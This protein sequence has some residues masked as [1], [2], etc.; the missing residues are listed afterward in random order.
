MGVGE[1]AQSGHVDSG[2]FRPKIGNPSQEI[3]K[4][5]PAGE[6]LREPVVA[7][8]TWVMN[9]QQVCPWGCLC[10]FRMPKHATKERSV[11]TFQV[12]VR[13]FAAKG[14]ILLASSRI[15]FACHR[16]F[17]MRIGTM[18]R[19]AW[20]SRGA[21]RPFFQPHP[22]HLNYYCKINL[23]FSPLYIL[24]LFLKP[25]KK[26][27]VNKIYIC[28]AEKR[29]GRWCGV[30]FVIVFCHSL[31]ELWGRSIKESDGSFYNNP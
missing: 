30:Y 4:N 12:S 25:Q 14:C 8:G 23:E 1:G 2:L 15:G 22:G 21:S 9:T 5:G 19:A 24:P 13:S 3:R 29:C 7:S 20:A 26:V 18:P 27:R 6:P 11:R 10:Y 31:L 16:S 17:K 28:S